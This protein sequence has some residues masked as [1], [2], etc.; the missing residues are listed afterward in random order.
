LESYAATGLLNR[1]P[2]GSLL[3]ADRGARLDA[4]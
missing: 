1:E 2:K 4:D 3:G